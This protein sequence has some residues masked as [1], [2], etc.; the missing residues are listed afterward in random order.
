M[1]S[2]IPR[3]FYLALSCLFAVLWSAVPQ[4]KS[5]TIVVDTTPEHASKTFLPSQT[6]GAAVDRMS[7]AAV[8][9]LFVKPTLDQVFA[10]GWQPVTY[11]QN[12]ELHIEAWHWNPQGTW[13]D[14]AGKGYFTGN[15][16]PGE[17]I[18]HSYG[19]PL[20]LRG[21]TRNDGTDANGYSRLTDGDLN[22]YWKSNPYL[23]KPFTGEDDALHPQWVV[24][25]L[26]SSVPVN[27]VRI[28]WADPYARRYLVQ[29]WNGEDP[30]KQA[31]KGVWQ[32]FPVGAVTDGTGGVA[33]LRLAPVPMSIRYLRLW[34]TESSNTCDNHGSADKRNCVGY[35]IQELYVGTIASDGTFYDAIRH[36][37]DQEQTT[38]L[39]SSIDPWHEPSDL[40]PRRRDQMGLDFF[41]TSGVTRGLPAMIPVSMVYDTPENA[42][43]EIAYV[44]KRG[45]PISFVELGEEPD[46]QFILPEDYA[47]LYLQ[48]ATAIHK[49]DPTLKLGGPIFEGVNEDILVWPDA[50]GRT[51]WL[52][53]FI[54]YLKA[55]DRISDLAFFSFE[56][57]PYD[58]CQISW[59][60]LYEEPTLVRH[61]AEVWRSDGLPPNVP[62]FITE[63]NISFAAGES[64]LDIWGALWLADYVGSSLTAGVDAV[65]YFHYV[66]VGMEYGCHNSP[67]AFALF[68]VDKDFK[69]QQPLSQFFAS[70]LINLE[71]VQPNGGQHRLFPAASDV[72]DPAGHTLVT[73][74]AVQRPDG[75]W[76]LMIINKDQHN[77]YRVKIKFHDGK[78]G[79]DRAF[80]GR[81]NLTT[82]GSAQ[83]QWHPDGMEGH[84]DPDGPAVKTMVNAG[85]EQMFDLPQAS[86]L[87]LRGNLR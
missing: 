5:Q 24:I 46:G 51:S 81:V 66:P 53:R 35:A 27:A 15:A 65:Y 62:M 52:G 21:T 4:A 16:T 60:S 67:G 1:Y 47:A 36:I 9:K 76:A 56:H 49:V 40:D 78:T 69:I 83:Y 50:Q 13:S 32:T 54:D 6:L 10:A 19:Y 43:A 80:S 23:T 11:R 31:T 61:I 87:V 58:P 34:M 72:R 75:Q 14:P 68:T 48:W 29:Y 25:D 17:P 12:T 42:A 28:A 22:T 84:A 85:P 3:P 57:Y 44:E 79:A 20:P 41:Y 37:P 55:H 73:A 86:I 63:S 26:S 7:E 30:I 39:V 8:E 38:T 71:W 77:P 18:R 33:T 64:F 74:Y 45:Y 59:D 82:F 70:Q 2:M